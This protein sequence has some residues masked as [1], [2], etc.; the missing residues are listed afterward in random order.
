[1][2]AIRSPGKAFPGSIRGTVAASAESRGS[3]V[4]TDALRDQGQDVGARPAQAPG[5]QAAPSRPPRY[6]VTR[7]TSMGLPFRK[8]ISTLSIKGHGQVGRHQGGG[9][10]GGSAGIRPELA[11]VGLGGAT[12]ERVQVEGGV[13][14]PRA[15]RTFF[16][17]VPGALHLGQTDSSHREDGRPVQP[18]CPAFFRC[19]LRAATLW[20]RGPPAAQPPAV[21]QFQSADPGGSCGAPS[22]RLPR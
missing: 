9:G 19:S 15:D 20:A 8:G 4:A 22:L 3:E 21:G 13:R 7:P 5:G 6:I 14:F 18:A 11:P 17:T 10:G 16:D 1:M 2:R 12:G